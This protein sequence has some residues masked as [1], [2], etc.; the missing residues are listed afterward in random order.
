M[1][2]GE[3]SLNLILAFVLFLLALLLGIL[4]F[5]AAADSQDNLVNISNQASEDN[6]IDRFFSIQ[7]NFINLDFNIIN[8]R[9]YYEII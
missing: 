1:N 9:A 3:V 2:K 4:I 7:E 6:F 5:N 8:E